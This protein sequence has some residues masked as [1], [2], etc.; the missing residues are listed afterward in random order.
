MARKIFFLATLVTV[1]LLFFNN[2]ALARCCP[3]IPPI[4][5]PDVGLLHKSAPNFKVADL[6]GKSVEL[7]KLK[8]QVVLL[9]FGTWEDIY[10]DVR[11]EQLKELH[12]KYSDND[13]AI[14]DFVSG[15]G[16]NKV[17]KENITKA[18]LDFTVV[19]P[20]NR[21][22]AKK[23]KVKDFPTAYLIDKNGN[24][25]KIAK[26][27]PELEDLDKAIPSLLRSSYSLRE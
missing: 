19:V 18:K 20:G 7:A 23:Y 11:L 6:I 1:T 26:S 25:V 22:V 15:T 12:A 2:A 10:K 14:V 9:E 4:F 27:Y 3:V 17:L 24:V 8:G 21:K 13:F 5:R 16:D